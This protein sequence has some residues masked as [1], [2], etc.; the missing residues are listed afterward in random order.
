MFGIR[1]G[2]FIAL[3]CTKAAP[4]F[5]G[6]KQSTV[7]NVTTADAMSVA[8]HCCMCC[9]SQS[10]MAVRTGSCRYFKRPN[11]T[12]MEFTTADLSSLDGR[13]SI[14]SLEWRFL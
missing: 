10:A 1:L 9:C 4:E 8:R 7:A 3:T 5:E 13:H 14:T 6:G 12:V 11:E 2:R